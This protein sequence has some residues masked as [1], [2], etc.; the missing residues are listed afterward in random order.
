GNFVGLAGADG[1][2]AF[3]EPGLLDDQP[4]D[5]ALALDADRPGEEIEDD[6]LAL[7]AGQGREL[8]QMGDRLALARLEQGVVEQGRKIGE[9]D[10][11]RRVL[12]MA[13][14]AEL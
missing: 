3:V 14:L 7:A 6:R 9:V 1:R 11:R 4:L 2:A 13:E 12:E 10:D 8:A 5:P